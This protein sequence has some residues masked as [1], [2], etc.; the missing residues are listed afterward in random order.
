MRFGTGLKSKVRPGGVPE[1][2]NRAVA[3]NGD[4]PAVAM[5]QEMSEPDLTR[6]RH[7]KLERFTGASVRRL[8]E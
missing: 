1:A 3:M 8:Q 6:H 5:K 7:P 2:E 4:N